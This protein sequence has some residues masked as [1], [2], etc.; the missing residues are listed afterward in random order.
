MDPGRVDFAIEGMPSGLIRGNL[1]SSSNPVPLPPRRAGAVL[2][3]A[4]S[5]GRR[6][7]LPGTAR[8]R[9]R[10]SWPRRRTA[11]RRLAPGSLTEL[12]CDF[13][14]GGEITL[15]LP[16]LA[17][18]AAGGWIALVEPPWQPYAR[19]GRCRGRPGAAR[20]RAGRPGGPG[21]ASNCSRAAALPAFSPGPAGTPIPGRCAASRWRPRGAPPSPSCGVVPP[22]RRRLRRHPASDPGAFAGRPFGAPPKR[23]GRAA[24]RCLTL[25]LPR[26]ER[27]SRALARPPFPRLPL[28]ALALGS[29][30]SAVAVRGRILGP[31]RPGGRSPARPALVH[32]P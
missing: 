5:G 32:R 14:G 10:P 17:P 7:G 19:P 31:G 30:P 1:I 4:T 2:E 26:P 22:Q 29:S 9:H 18:S 15:L 25:D 21:A 20:R 12:L 8:H 13:P 24:G 3:R 6:P 28:E 23:R 27:R 16:A 11:R